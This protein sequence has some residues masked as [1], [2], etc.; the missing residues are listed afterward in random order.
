MGFFFTNALKYAKEN[1]FTSIAYQ[2]QSSGDLISSDIIIW[3]N[4]FENVNKPIFY[5]NKH[6][7]EFR[8]RL[9]A[10]LNLRLDFSEK[11]GILSPSTA[12]VK[13]VVV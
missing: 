13:F 11:Y 5:I 6:L 7:N 10:I 3:Q 12:W 2:L 1:N 4:D 8:T 9:P